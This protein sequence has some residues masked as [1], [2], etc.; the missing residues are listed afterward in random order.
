MKLRCQHYALRLYSP[1]VSYPPMVMAN[2]TLNSIAL[3]FLL[4]SCAR[5]T[6][7]KL[8]TPAAVA[9]ITSAIKAD[10]VKELLLRAQRLAE[11][12]AHREAGMLFGQVITRAPER[13]AAYEGLALVQLKEDQLQQAAKTCSSGLAR[14]ST[15]IPLYN[16]LSAAYAGDGR[17]A[18][19]ISA[20]EKAVALRPDFAL[21]YTNLGGL[22][23]RL[24]Q[25]T[26][27]EYYLGRALQLNRDDP[28]LHRRYGELLLKTAKVDSALSEFSAALKADPDNET[29]HFLYGKTAEEI[30]NKERAL[31]AYKKA[32]RL[33]PGFA[34]AH[35]RTALLARR[36]GQTALA[37]SALRAHKKLREIGAPDL[38]QPRE[39]KKR[40]AAILDSPEEPLHHFR[41]AQFFAR[42]S[43][44]REAESRFLR[45]LQLNP[46]DYRAHNHIGNIHLKQQDPTTAL[47]H[48]VDALRIRP[49]F[50]PALV[51]AGN[52]SM[53]LQDPNAAANYYGRATQHAPKAA[54]IWLQ[55]ARAHQAQQQF[56]L[57][58]ASLQKG[59]QI[60]NA[61]PQIQR[62]MLDLL[63][64]LE[65]AH[66]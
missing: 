55:L 8:P 47:T 29:L 38:L 23:T 48:F 28:V 45:V 42:H 10:P 12:G 14:D 17:H 3:L 51:N 52:A 24:G 19:A 1:V 33:D 11:R 5:E 41:L 39:L 49:D 50:A 16:M 21:G 66:Q 35:Y 61:S 65:N 25:Y 40:R 22:Y 9:P 15:A 54:I 44:Y 46:Q 56:H 20:L 43:Y 37:D 4:V 31:A 32:R 6:S 13:I 18:L 64:R 26:Q 30:G 57:A 7:E 36:L 2:S 58:I 60:P 34:D 53:L 59:L 27:A 63:Q 62:S